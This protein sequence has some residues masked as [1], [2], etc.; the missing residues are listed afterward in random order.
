MK[1]FAAFFLL[2]L[3]GTA[4]GR[5]DSLAN[6]LQV[7]GSIGMGRVSGRQTQQALSL[8]A[9]YRTITGGVQM[10][11]SGKSDGYLFEND[12]LLG[13]RFYFGRMLALTMSA[14]YADIA[15]ETGHHTGDIVPQNFTKA[16][17]FVFDAE[18]DLA[19]PRPARRGASAWSLYAAYYANRNAKQNLDGYTFGVKFCPWR[20]VPMAER[21]KE[22]DRQPG[23]KKKKDGQVADDNAPDLYH[24][25]FAGVSTF[26]LDVM[27]G[28][29]MMRPAHPSKGYTFY[30]GWRSFSMLTHTFSSFVYPD[31]TLK[32]PMLGF[33]FDW[34]TSGKHGVREASVVFM[35]RALYADHVWV[36]TM[37]ADRGTEWLISRERYDLCVLGRIGRRTSSLDHF[38][39]GI[40]IA[41]GPRLSVYHTSFYRSSFTGSVSDPHPAPDEGFQWREKGPDAGFEF[42]VQLFFGGGW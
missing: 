32:G 29:A 37:D 25:V 19:I 36:G 31:R 39:S 28:Y 12:F 17:G 21:R 22:A 15:F 7:E 8:C 34:Y 2:L 20:Y 26:D 5:T 3:C 40:Y 1:N 27:A 42:H 18:A 24:Y 30:G 33:G 38:F 13:K 16:G 35:T 41:A 4:Y 11:R 14:G 10:L 23:G 9:A 6:K